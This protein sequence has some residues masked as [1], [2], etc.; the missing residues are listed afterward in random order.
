MTTEMATE[1]LK[2]N[3]GISLRRKPETGKQ[4]L[5]IPLPDEK[6]LTRFLQNISE[7]LNAQGF[8]GT[9]SLPHQKS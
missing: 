2:E 9:S 1:T 7:L 4:S 5:E 3:I 6:T 8:S